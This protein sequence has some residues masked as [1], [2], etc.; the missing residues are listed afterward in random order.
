MR[1]FTIRRWQPPEPE[2]SLPLFESAES[3]PQRLPPGQTTKRT[4]D[5]AAAS[6]AHAREYISSRIVTWLR[7]RPQGATCEEAAIALSLRAATCSARFVDLSRPPG[8][9]V[10]SGRT[11]KTTSGR[12][13]T[14]WI[15]PDFV[16]T[17]GGGAA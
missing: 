2:K 12:A 15:H 3:Q 5:A 6:V 16:T 17:R 7:G 8:R 9:I 4:R 11:R 1:E 13:A 14:V 10:D